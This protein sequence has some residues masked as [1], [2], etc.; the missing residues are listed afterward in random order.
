MTIPNERTRALVCTI[1]FLEDLQAPSAT[2][3]VPRAVRERA[4]ALARHFPTLAAI[5]MAHMTCPH[6]Y[7][8]VA[9]LSC[10]DDGPGVGGENG[11]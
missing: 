5:E 1:D 7:G 10:T 2:P 3:R 11:G 8:P 4:R 6:L 9:H